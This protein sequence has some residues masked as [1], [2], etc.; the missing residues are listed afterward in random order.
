MKLVAL[1]AAWVTGLLIGLEMNA[2]LPALVLLSLAALILACLL[3]AKGL[4]FWPALLIVVLFMGL[5][6]ME[7][8][9]GPEVL[10]P[11]GGLQSITVRGLV[12][13]D[14]EVSGPGVAFTIAVDAVDRGE[15]WEGKG[16]KVLVFAS[17]PAELVEARGKPY[18]RYGDRLEL[19]GRL[20][21]PPDLGDFDYR[22]YLANQG[23]HST[24]PF[25]QEIRLTGI[26]NYLKI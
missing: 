6:R 21:K 18:F 12:V 7:V 16:G 8:S 24:M 13:S 10:K 17:P 23:I 25:P 19:T 9:D 3:R 5:I 11:S 15:G 26:R 20:E 22:A 14:P 2:Y 1:A 4:S